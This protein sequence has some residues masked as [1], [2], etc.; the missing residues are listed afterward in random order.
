VGKQ[1]LAAAEWRGISLARFSALSSSHQG[2]LCA[3]SS[4]FKYQ[5]IGAGGRLLA[6]SGIA[7]L[8]WRLCSA[9]EALSITLP[10]LQRCRVFGLSQLCDFR[11]CCWLPVCTRAGGGESGVQYETRRRCSAGMCWVLVACGEGGVTDT[12]DGG[13]LAGRQ[14]LFVLAFPLLM[15]DEERHAMRLLTEEDDGRFGACCWTALTPWF[16]VWARRVGTTAENAGGQRGRRAVSA[17]SY[18]RLNSFLLYSS[19]M[20]TT[21]V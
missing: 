13:S 12:R 7:Q 6:N 11:R 16:C 4:A 10:S 19:I 14:P 2:E 20:S 21:P 3:I 5:A 18:L 9:H 15:K 1:R 8:R 17:T